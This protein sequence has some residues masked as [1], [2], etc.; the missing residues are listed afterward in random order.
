MTLHHLPILSSGRYA[1]R[2]LLSALI[3]FRAH[4]GVLLSGSVAFHLL[5][6]VVPTFLL[7]L[8]VMSHVVAEDQLLAVLSG[9]MELLLPGQSEALKRDLAN[10][11]AHREV[12]GWL[13]VGVMLIFSSLAFS[14]LEDA[15]AVIFNHRSLDRRRHFLVSAI[16][17]YLY[18]MT[19][20]AGLA[21]VTL[22]IGAL[23][24]LQDQ[25][26]T[27]LGW[28][29]TPGGLKNEV[30]YLFAVAGVIVLF[31]LIYFGLPVGPI[32]WRQA[33]AG[34]IIAGILWEFMRQSL[35]WY[36]ATLSLVNVIY[37]SLASAVVAL[38]SLEVA[39]LILLFGAQ[40][41]AEHDR[42]AEGGD[43]KTWADSRPVALS[44]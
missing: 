26:V 35:L 16:L 13:G 30:L 28:T 12:I 40:I 18:L 23:G 22:F 32:S 29:L 11:L 39:A 44:G 24:L 38:L 37:G 10:F 4:Q 9:Y 1:G 8:V 27:F 34:G 5:L 17:P 14:V 19:I 2:L 21:L 33:L 42:I 7:I 41:I 43:F 3:S 6:S 31:A 25:Q 36:F 15:F 20:G